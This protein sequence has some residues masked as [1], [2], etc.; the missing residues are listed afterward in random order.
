MGLIWCFAGT[1]A[2][3]AVSCGLFDS[4]Y[5]LLERALGLHLDAPDLGYGHMLWRCLFVFGAAVMLWRLANRRFL[6]SNAGYDIMLGVILGSVLSRGINGS[7]AFFP[8]LWAAALLIFFHH[9]LSTFA[10]RWGWCS[11]LVKGR[12]RVVVKNGKI[13]RD[14]L[15]RFKITENELEENLRLNANEADPS[16]V[17]EARLEQNGRISVVKMKP[18]A[19]R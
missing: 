8:T 1:R 10:Y 16:N 13:N 11:K 9:L 5:R 7:A 12:P 19:R 18:S 15:R 14:E 6:G 3:R 4:A 17:A 2:P